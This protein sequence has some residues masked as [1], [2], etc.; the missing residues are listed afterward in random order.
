MRIVVKISRRRVTASMAAEP[1]DKMRTPVL[2]LRTGSGLILGGGTP[3]ERL[4]HIAVGGYRHPPVVVVVMVVVVAVP[5]LTEAA[6]QTQG[7]F[8]HLLERRR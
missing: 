3:H 8:E 2:V 1:G 4:W 5:V 7:G 6:R